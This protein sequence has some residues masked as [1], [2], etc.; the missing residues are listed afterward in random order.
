MGEHPVV[1]VGETSRSIVER[2]R[3]HWSGYLKNH[4]DNHMVKHQT[5]VHGGEPAKFTM[6]VV[7]SHPSA[8]SRQVSG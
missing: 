3:E 2:S 4:E 8:L 6:R 5:M 7:G 1:Y